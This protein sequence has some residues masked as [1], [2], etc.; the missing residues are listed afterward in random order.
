MYICHVHSVIEGSVPQMNFR[1][2]IISGND[3][4]TKILA[5]VIMLEQYVG[6]ITS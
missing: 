4:F 2:K 3:R 6:F 5:D 1:K